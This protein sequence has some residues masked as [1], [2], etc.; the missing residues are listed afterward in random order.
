VDAWFTASMK[1]GR[2]TP[3]EGRE[4]LSKYRSGLYGYTYIEKD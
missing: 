3:D 1:A 2:I 4:F